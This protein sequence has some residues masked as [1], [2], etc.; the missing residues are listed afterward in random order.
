MTRVIRTTITLASASVF[1]LTAY[2][3]LILWA[4]GSPD[5]V[6]AIYSRTVYPFIAENL[7][8]F[9][10]R[11]P[12]SLGEIFVG[13]EVLLL[14][15]I[16]VLAMMKSIK[17]EFMKSL[18]CLLAAVL[19]LSVNLLLYE[20]QWGLNNYRFDSIELFELDTS[21]ITVEDLAESYA[22]LVHQSNELKN[23]L[24]VEGI[25]TKDE[26]QKEVFLEDAYIGYVMLHADYDFISPKAVKVKELLISPIF[27]SSGYTGIYLPF[28]S[29]ANVNSMPVPYS[30]PFV[31]SHEIAH[32]KGFASEDEANFAGFMACY[33]HPDLL[34][35][36]SGIMAMASYVGSSLYDSDADLFD[37]IAS[38][39]SED[40]LSDIRYR[41]AFW[42]VHVKEKRADV[43]NR[44]NDTF[45]KANNQPE[46]ILSYS[47]VTE[48][49]VR[50]YM[51]G[52]F[53]E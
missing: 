50:G 15:F 46:G 24:M 52:L 3:L 25:D 36:Y 8:A 19:L 12:L 11:F 20:V 33:K 22:F 39:W 17:R 4:K 51:S 41:N 45:L 44:I 16:A 32:Q 30:L 29:E 26:K 10:N 21:E 35:R 1:C 40:V 49:F 48:L 38:E 47:K 34:Y 43:H 13:L 7:N 28:F 42:D 53:S 27:S 6:E 18:N 2:V 23:R 37:E 9:S 31:A 5:A 14:I